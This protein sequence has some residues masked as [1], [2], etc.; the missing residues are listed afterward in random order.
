[1]FFRSVLVLIRTARG[2]PV[3]FE[4]I[5]A[6]ARTPSDVGAEYIDGAGRGAARRD[7]GRR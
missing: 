4:L 2:E 7:A 1:M 5:V 6:R 3:D